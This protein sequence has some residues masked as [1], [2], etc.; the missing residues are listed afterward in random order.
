MPLYIPIHYIP[1]YTYI[2]PPIY[3]YIPIYRLHLVSLLNY[4]PP[5]KL[6]VS[7]HYR[8]QLGVYVVMTLLFH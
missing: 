3:T 7:I 4:A 8:L 2:Y 1:L 6:S 5:F